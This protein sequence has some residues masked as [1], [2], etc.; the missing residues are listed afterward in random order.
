MPRPRPFTCANACCTDASYATRLPPVTAGNAVM[1]SG[2]AG[3]PRPAGT[4]IHC[5]RATPTLAAIAV[6]TPPTARLRGGE[7]HTAG[8]VAEW[9]LDVSKGEDCEPAGGPGPLPVWRPIPAGG[10]AV[11]VP[12]TGPASA[13]DTTSRTLGLLRTWVRSQEA[14]ASM[15]WSGTASADHQHRPQCRQ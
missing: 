13:T 15:R 3:A 7:R 12:V 8:G 14:A 5:S 6:A 1:V 2:V 9:I 4:G 11:P 10:Q